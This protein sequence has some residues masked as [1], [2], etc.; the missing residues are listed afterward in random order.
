MRYTTTT[1]TLRYHRRRLGFANSRA[2]PSDLIKTSSAAPTRCLCIFWLNYNSK[3]KQKKNL[4]FFCVDGWSTEGGNAKEKS[5][6]KRKPSDAAAAHTRP[7][8]AAVKYWLLCFWSIVRKPRFLIH[9][10]GEMNVL[11][12][13]SRIIFKCAAACTYICL[14]DSSEYTQESGRRLPPVMES[15]RPSRN[16]VNHDLSL[17][18]SNWW[19]ARSIVEVCI[20]PF[21]LIESLNRG[22]IGETGRN[23]QSIC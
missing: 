12:H 10:H 8:A 14:V 20:Y 16:T 23:R 13:F 21:I 1:S 17:T 15:R 7:C 11:A 2:T 22:L 5:M 4:F 19:M 3:T 18:A 6:T 9:I